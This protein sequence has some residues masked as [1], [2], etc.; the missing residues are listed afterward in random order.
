MKAIDQ[1]SGEGV[2]ASQSWG[3]R[4]TI[5]DMVNRG[6]PDAWARGPILADAVYP[7]V[8]VGRAVTDG[9]ALELVLHPGAEAV[10]SDIGIDR[11]VPGRSYHIIETDERFTAG[12]DG[13]ARL[14]VA[15]TGRTPLTI[16]PVA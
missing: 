14:T 7:D 6:L 3:G 9:A 4:N 10:R 13:K 16:V 12:L 15:L 11:L 1:R 5:R 8:I 2:A